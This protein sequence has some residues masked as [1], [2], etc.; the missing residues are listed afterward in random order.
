MRDDA[1][2]FVTRSL[3][4]RIVPIG[5]VRAR[6]LGVAQELADALYGRLDPITGTLDT[7]GII[8]WHQCQADTWFDRARS[9]E[10]VADHEDRVLCTMTQIARMD[11]EKH[12]H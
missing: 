4:D 9:Q 10:W 7:T 2:F 8:A 6:D 12:N 3:A 5:T 11:R 1:P